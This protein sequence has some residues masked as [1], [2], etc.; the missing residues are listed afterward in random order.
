MEW[1]GKTLSRTRHSSLDYDVLVTLVNAP[2]KSEP[3]KKSIA[4]VFR[5]KAYKIITALGAEAV[6]RTPV[7]P[8][9]NRIYF[10]FEDTADG[11]GVMLSKAPNAAQALRARFSILSDTEEKTIAR[12][13]VGEHSI[14]YDKTEGAYYIERKGDR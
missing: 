8:N 2:T 14:K 11:I 12:V 13:W 3:A 7:F 10:A 4:L 6:K 5:N 1:I 9:S